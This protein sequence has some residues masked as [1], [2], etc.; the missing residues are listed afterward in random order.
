MWETTQTEMIL[1]HYISLVSTHMISDTY[2]YSYEET[3]IK[4]AV[5]ENCS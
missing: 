2:C 3:S 1:S 5:N 4:W